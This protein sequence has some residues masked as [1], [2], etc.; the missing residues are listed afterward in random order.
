[1]HLLTLKPCQL[2]HLS[3]RA[4]GLSHMARC[5]EV[6]TRGPLAPTSPR[7]RGEVDLRAEPWRSEANRVRGLVHKLRFAATPP[8]PDSFAALGNRPLPPRGARGS[9]RRGLAAAARSL[10]C[11]PGRAASAARPGTHVPLSR[12]FFSCRGTWIPALALRARPG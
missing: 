3:P 11:H 5:L 2:R 6:A 9:K 12:L 8:H 10:R 4:A 1:M 7:V